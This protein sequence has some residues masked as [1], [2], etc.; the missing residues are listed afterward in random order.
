MSTTFLRSE[1]WASGA[2]KSRPKI[3][4]KVARLETL[5]KHS[6]L[7]CQC[8][9]IGSRSFAEQSFLHAAGIELLDVVDRRHVELADGLGPLEILAVMDVLD[10]HHA[11]EVFVLLMVVEGELDQ[12][13]Q[14]LERRQ[15]LDVE[16]ALA[17][18]G[19][20]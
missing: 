18:R 8:S 19:P 15:M 9:S 16:L 5:K 2:P 1:A 14:R 6:A 11:D 12:P 7:I 13:L 10:H 20:G 3:F 4:E 17:L